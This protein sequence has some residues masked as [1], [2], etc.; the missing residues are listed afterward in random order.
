M[1]SLRKIGDL[2]CITSCLALPGFLMDTLLIC[3]SSCLLTKGY[4]KK[5]TTTTTTIIIRTT[6]L[7]S[8]MIYSL[9]KSL[10][11]NWQKE[12]LGTVGKISPERCPYL[13]MT[14]QKFKVKQ[15]MIIHIS[16]QLVSKIFLFG[17]F[18]CNNNNTSQYKHCLN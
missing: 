13:W 3:G 2:S 8:W 9:G 5:K 7:R 14:D 6:T 10:Q 12:N 18:Y 16:T 15:F 4:R 1:P 17:F 11:I